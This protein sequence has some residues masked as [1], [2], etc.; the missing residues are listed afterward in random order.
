MTSRKLDKNGIILDFSDLKAIV[1]DRVID[2][3][4][5]TLLNDSFDNPTAELLVQSF[6]QEIKDALENL[7]P[8]VFLKRL[9][10]YETEDSRAEIE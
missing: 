6:W 7:F 4:D 9:V 8:K 2:P 5:H 10:L 3:Y 1:K